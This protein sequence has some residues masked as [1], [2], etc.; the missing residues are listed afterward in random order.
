MEKIS[1]LLKILL[2]VKCGDLIELS[3]FPL[4]RHTTC[5]RRWDRGQ[6]LRPLLADPADF[7]LRSLR[8]EPGAQPSGS[9]PPS[10]TRHPWATCPTTLLRP[11][12]AGAGSGLSIRPRVP[13]DYSNVRPRQAPPHLVL[14]GRVAPQHFAPDRDF[15]GPVGQLRLRRLLLPPPAAHPPVAP[16]GPGL[17]RAGRSKRGRGLESRVTGRRAVVVALSRRVRRRAC[18]CP[19]LTRQPG[20]ALSAETR[21]SVGGATQRPASSRRR[22]HAANP[23]PR[24]RSAKEEEL[25]L[26]RKRPTR[27]S[28]DKFPPAAR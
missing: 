26:R 9:G 3:S 2:G 24:S 23:R 28:H 5:P 14:P 21:R 7:T 12:R 17:G 27:G 11:D 1:H 18:G 6:L 13:A 4:L 20:S 15:E 8:G 10:S 19:F 22:A 25:S 16:P